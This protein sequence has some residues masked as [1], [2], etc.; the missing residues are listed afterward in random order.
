M[1]KQGQ[2]SSRAA[3]CASRLVR[4]YQLTVSPAMHA[5]LGPGS[6]CRFYPTCSCYAREALAKHGFFTGAWLS[7][8]RI[9]RCHPWRQAGFDPVPDLKSEHRQGIAAHFKTN[10]DG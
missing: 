5:I 1:S 8:R 10:S 9:L 3:R 7:L 4:I 2:Y 6:G